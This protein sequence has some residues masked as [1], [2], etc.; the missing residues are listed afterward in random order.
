[1]GFKY[2][3][4]KRPIK[5]SLF[6]SLSHFAS[7]PLTAPMASLA[8]P[9]AL[10]SLPA[11]LRR[12]PLRFLFSSSVSTPPSL[13]PIRPLSVG[14]LTYDFSGSFFE[15]GGDE[16]RDGP[17]AV[18]VA[19]VDLED[20]EE[21]QCP[22]GLRQY[23]TMAVLRPDMT[24]DERLVLIQRY[25]EVVF[26]FSFHIYFVLSLWHSPEDKPSSVFKFLIC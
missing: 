26:N 16:E 5:A 24:E 4:H 17:S 25:E 7:Y 20:K 14:A 10:A 13:R 21:P 11:K 9:V 22:P 2:G 3:R 15:D 18:S 23:E 19:S 12:A 8:S 6:N 1:M